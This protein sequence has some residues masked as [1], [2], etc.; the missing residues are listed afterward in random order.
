VYAVSGTARRQEE[1]RSLEPYREGS[2]DV[3]REGLR[4]NNLKDPAVRGTVALIE[5]PGF[6]AK[7]EVEELVR[8]LDEIVIHERDSEVR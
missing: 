1:E 5:I 7:E 4:T 3:L 6:L 2:L 8:G